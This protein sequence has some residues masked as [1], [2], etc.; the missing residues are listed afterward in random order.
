MRPEEG[1][2]PCSRRR[3]HQVGLPRRTI[4][5]QTHDLAAAVAKHPTNR[6]AGAISGGE[7]GRYWLI[8]DTSGA[9]GCS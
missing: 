9:S 8:G 3:T 4:P 7:E 2:A 6:A 5:L 1:L